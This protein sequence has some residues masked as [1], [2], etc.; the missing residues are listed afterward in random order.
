MG[1]EALVRW[2]HPEYGFMNPGEFIPLFERIG[3]IRD[4]DYYVWTQVCRDINRWKAKGLPLVPVSIN[5][6]RRDFENPNLADR[7]MELIQ[8]NGIEPELIHIELTES[9]F[10]DDPKRISDCLETL[11]RLF[12]PDHPEQP[13]F[14]HP[15]DRHEHHPSG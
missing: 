12:L 13:G 14:G 2:N 11:H 15:E 5:L 9:A 4:L 6:S 7:I 10:S 8:E 1:A 3:F